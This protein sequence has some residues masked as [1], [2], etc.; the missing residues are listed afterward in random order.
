MMSAFVGIDVS[1]AKLDVALIREKQTTYLQVHN[2]PDG[3][4]QLH[5]WLGQP[6][7]ITQIALEATGRYGEGCAHDLVAQGYAVSYLNPKLIHAFA[8]LHLHRSKTD[9]ADAWLIARYCQLHRPG[10]WRPQANGHAQLQ[11][12]SRRVEALQKMRQQEVNRSQSGITHPLVLHSIQQIIAVF[13]DQ[14]RHLTQAL[15]D[16]IQQ[17]PALL[18]DFQLLVS[19]KGIGRKTAR[20]LLAELGDLRRFDSPKQLVAFVG[21]APQHIQSGTSVH[22]RST[23]SKQ[24]SSRLRAALYMP[25]IVAKRWNPACH[26]LAQRLEQRHK[27]GKVIVIAVLRKLLHQIFGVLK[28]GI[29][30]DPDLSFS[31]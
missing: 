10:L 1:K 15:D 28:S 31:S 22:K 19:I 4:T 5:Q 13:D 24:G 8:R 3:W 27:H 16:L 23:I 6:E 17:Q 14:I 12:L 21:V 30:F 11:Q 20:L 9:R 25:A 26:A 7:V 29:P 2:T 18:R